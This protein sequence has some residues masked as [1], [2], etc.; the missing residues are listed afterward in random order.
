MTHQ[1]MVRLFGFTLR[2][3]AKEAEHIRA[4]DPF[5]LQGTSSS[6]N[7]FMYLS[8]KS[9]HASHGLHYHS[10]YSNIA[11]VV[12]EAPQGSDSRNKDW[13][14]QIC[15]SWRKDQSPHKTNNLKDSLDNLSRVE[16]IRSIA[17]QW[18]EPFTSFIS[19]IPE[20]TNVKQIDLEDFAPCKGLRATDKAIILGDAFHA[21]S[22]CKSAL[23]MFTDEMPA[24]T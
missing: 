16:T 5:F 7:V 10:Q 13:L 21:M 6:S 2:V 1:I 18:A 15:I 23:K 20:T 17:R 8:C 3:S 19:Q 12:L 24:L 11:C 22:M 4:L 14:Y 9:S